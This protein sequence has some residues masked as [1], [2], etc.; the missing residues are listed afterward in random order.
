MLVLADPNSSDFK[1]QLQY[2]L[3]IE[4]IKVTDHTSSN[5]SQP[6]IVIDVSTY[7]EDPR[8]LQTASGNSYITLDI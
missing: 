4:G 2:P 6:K 8:S 1:K 3:T 7:T 5:A